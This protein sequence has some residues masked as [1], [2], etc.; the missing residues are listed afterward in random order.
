MEAL[1]ATQPQ[2]N[3]VSTCPAWCI[4]G[5][6]LTPSLYGPGNSCVTAASQSGGSCSYC[7]G[8]FG[9]QITPTP[10]TS[11]VNIASIP[12]VLTVNEQFD[13]VFTTGVVPGSLVL[14]GTLG[15]AAS[16][17][18]VFSEQTVFNDTVHILPSSSWPTGSVQSLTITAENDLGVTFTETVNINVVAPPAPPAPEPEPIPWWIICFFTKAC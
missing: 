6:C 14:S 7:A 3:P 16:G 18:H 9:A 15:N 11:T 17:V 4:S 10:A 13:I 2:A 8:Y 1:K 5:Q 12:T